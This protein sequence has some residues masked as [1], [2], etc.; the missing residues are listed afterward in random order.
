M[1]TLKL[2]AYELDKI[3]WKRIVSYLPKQEPLDVAGQ[4]MCCSQ[5]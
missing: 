5:A 1:F 2:Y 4:A 3:T